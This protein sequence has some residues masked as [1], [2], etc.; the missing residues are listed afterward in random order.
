MLVGW[1]HCSANAFSYTVS[2]G[3]GNCVWKTTNSSIPSI[4]FLKSDLIDADVVRVD[5]NGM[6]ADSD[7]MKDKKARY[8]YSVRLKARLPLEDGSK[9]KTEKAFM[10]APYD[11]GRRVSK[12][13]VTNIRAFR[14]NRN[15]A[16][17]YTRGK[18]ITALGIVCV[19]TG[20]V[21]LLL[22]CLFGQWME[23]SPRRMK[24]AS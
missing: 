24:K 9:M 1:F 18:S 6:Y 10:F 12:S 4:S 5:E 22:S 7:R 17:N 2:C 15:E 8:G 14:D 11:L 13:A 16:F 23:I 21:S 19:F 3:Q 20:L